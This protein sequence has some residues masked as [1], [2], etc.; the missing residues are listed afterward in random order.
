MKIHSIQN[1]ANNSSV[2]KAEIQ[3]ASPLTSFGVKGTKEIP[4]MTNAQK[5]S[6]I[7]KNQQ[8]SIVSKSLMSEN[9]LM[10]NKNKAG[11]ARKE[12]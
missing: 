4:N 1:H 3:K 8:S 11:G 10:F 9:S 2:V 6:T 12:R 5:A 7:N